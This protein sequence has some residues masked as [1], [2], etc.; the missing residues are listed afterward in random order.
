MI[1]ILKFG[2]EKC[3]PCKA[4]NEFLKDNTP[5]NVEIISVT[6]ETHPELFQKHGVRMIPLLIQIDEKGDE[7]KRWRGESFKF[8]VRHNNVLKE[9]K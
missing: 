9:F 8:S 3:A 1:R 5:P 7:V 6:R 2:N 4:L